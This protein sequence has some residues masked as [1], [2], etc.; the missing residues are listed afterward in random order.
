MKNIFLLLVAITFISCSIEEDIQIEK[1]NILVIGNS[2]VLHPP[3][4]SI[5][6]N[7]NHG[8]AAT[9]SDKDFCSLLSKNIPNNNMEKINMWAWE[10]SWDYESIGKKTK[11]C[12]IL[13]VKVG[14]NVVDE[15]N[16]KEHLNNLV[17]LYRD[18]YTKIYIVSTALG[19]FITNKDNIMQEFCLEKGYNF[20][21]L[22]SMQDDQTNFAWMEWENGGIGCHPSDKG[23]EFIA[24]SIL[25]KINQ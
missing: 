21:D 22:R 17:N 24:N 6:W 12:D 9:S 7:Y 13:V 19:G 25:E 8:M 18:S 20:I 23:M 11:P 15:E 1:P 16:F 14:E 10:Y 5:G 4:E 2:I 3:N